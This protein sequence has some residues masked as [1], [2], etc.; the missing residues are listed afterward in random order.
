MAQEALA[1]VSSHSESS[2]VMVQLVTAP[3]E[4]KLSIEDDGKGFDLSAIPKDRYGLVGI[5]ER[6]KLLGG[7]VGV[8]S[9]LGVGTRI[10]IR[11]PLSTSAPSE[12][13]PRLE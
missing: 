8:E 9:S 5:N 11:V 12:E 2:K 4:I 13:K 1:N 3:Q 7:R 6:A 10:E